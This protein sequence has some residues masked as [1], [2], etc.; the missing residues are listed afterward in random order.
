MTGGGGDTDG[1]L[2]TLSAAA[3]GSV[4]A[5]EI[6]QQRN[7]QPIKTDCSYQCS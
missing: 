6:V 4:T 2:T 3:A 7:A 5:A 1:N